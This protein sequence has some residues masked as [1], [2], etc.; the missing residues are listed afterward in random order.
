MNTNRTLRV[1][2]LLNLILTGSWSEGLA[3]PVSI[4]SWEEPYWN[5]KLTEISLLFVLQAHVAI[6]G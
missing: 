6:L 1:C 2:I 5:S 4:C 3:L